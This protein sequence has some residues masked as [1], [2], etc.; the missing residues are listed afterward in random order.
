VVVI[1]LGTVVSLASCGG[2]RELTAPPNVVLV[3]IDALRADHLSCYG[4]DRHT[5]PFLDQLAARGTR[6]SHAFVNTHGT[7]PSHATM[8]SSLYGSQLY[9]L[10]TPRWKLLV[11]RQRAVRKLYHLR[12]DPAER[13]NVAARFPRLLAELEEWRAARPQLETPT[14]QLAEIPADTRERLKA[15]GYADRV[16]P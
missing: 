11:N 8:L 9:A 1:A 15:L 16:R 2:G 13:N 4:Y 3:S 10:R 5:S 12:R 14:Q 7:P 6:F